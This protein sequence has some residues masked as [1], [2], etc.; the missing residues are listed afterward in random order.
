M[1]LKAYRDIEEGEELTISYLTLGQTSSHRQ[2]A[3]SSWG[4]NCSCS[5]CSLRK[6]EKA[7]SDIRRKLIAQLT[8]KIMQLWDAGDDTAAISLAEESVQ[9]IVDEGLEHLLTEQYAL[10]AK[11]W[12]MLGKKRQRGTTVLKGEER[13]QSEI[14]ARK[15]WIL[16]GS[17]GFLGTKWDGHDDFD[18]EAFLELVSDGIK[19]VMLW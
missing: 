10:V 3:I 6:P 1:A 18:L 9:I 19:E 14:W 13:V 16:L 15:S 7:A 12:L 11:L 5:L 17:M 2:H 4:F 8:P